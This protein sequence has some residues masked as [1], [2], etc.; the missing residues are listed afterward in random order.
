MILSRIINDRNSVFQPDTELSPTENCGPLQLHAD[1]VTELSLNSGPLQLH[2]DA[3]TELSLNCGPLQ[4]HA[5]AVNLLHVLIVF[6]ERRV[7]EM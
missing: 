6:W 1:A 5:D 7:Y 2:A 4:L 3:V